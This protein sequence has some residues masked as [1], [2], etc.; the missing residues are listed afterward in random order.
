LINQIDTTLRNK[1]QCIIAW[2]QE[3]VAYTDGVNNPT[4]RKSRKQ[5]L[6]INTNN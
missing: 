6:A 5:G 3:I 2:L 1:S 4:I